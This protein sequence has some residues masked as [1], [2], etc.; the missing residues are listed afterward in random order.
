[1]ETI[2]VL[3]QNRYFS[4]YLILI[5]VLISCNNKKQEDIYS[6][7]SQKL[8]SY[9]I[10]SVFTGEETYLLDTLNYLSV[11]NEEYLSIAI[12]EFREDDTILSKSDSLEIIRSF[13]KHSD[14]L[15]KK[16]MG[17]KAREIKVIQ[18]DFDA[19]LPIKLPHLNDKISFKNPSDSNLVI[20]SSAPFFNDSFDRCALCLG[21]F[22]HNS[23][24][25]FVTYFYHFLFKDNNSWKLH[26]F[27]VRFKW[28]GEDEYLMIY[29]LKDIEY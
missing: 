29:D 3:I 25:N 19:G 21:L 10:D 11:L 9:L 23:S 12:E 26:P 28:E 7:N 16:A 15:F 8:F 17:E 13:Q 18:V 4:F 27:T 24:G 2:N 6:E 5:S 1:M 22:T 20:L 14:L